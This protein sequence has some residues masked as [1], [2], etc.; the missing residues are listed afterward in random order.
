MGRKALLFV[1]A[2]AAMLNNNETTTPNVYIAEPY[3]SAFF[4]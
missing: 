1:V 3:K 4:G 2:M